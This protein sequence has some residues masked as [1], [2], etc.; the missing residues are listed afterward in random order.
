MISITKSRGAFVRQSFSDPN[1]PTKRLASLTGAIQR[2]VR[3]AR[4]AGE[5]RE[6][7]QRYRS[8]YVANTNQASDRDQ[9]RG[10]RQAAPFEKQHVSRRHA[11]P[12]RV[13]QR[14]DSRSDRERKSRYPEEGSSRSA[15][16]GPCRQHFSRTEGDRW[17]LPRRPPARDNSLQLEN[18]DQ[19]RSRYINNNRDDEVTDSRQSTESLPYREGTGRPS[20]QRSIAWQ[21]PPYNDERGV[22]EH[23]EHESMPLR[24][25]MTVPL[26][27]PRTSAASEFIYGTS[28]VF[29]ALQARARKLYTLYIYDGDSGAE[30]REG[31]K[32]IL[33]PAQEY[34][35]K[36]K[37]ISGDG[38][39]LLD[40]MAQGRPHNGYVLEASQL[41][42]TPAKA[43][44]SVMGRGVHFAFT[45]G[46][47][48]AEDISVNGT[49]RVIQC[50]SRRYPFV[51]MLDSI[52][53]PG[54]LGAVIRS[55][56]F[57]GVDAIALVDHGVA[58]I[59][60]VALKAS[61][62]AAEY[63]RYLSIKKDHDFVKTSQNNGW[64]FF[65]AVAP[66][67][68]SASR[69]GPPSVR[70][71][72]EEALMK[73]PCVLMLGGEGGGLKPR[74]QNEADGIV[75]I[76]GVDSPHSRVGLDSLNVSVA[77]ALLMQTFL[78][79]SNGDTRPKGAATGTGK[80]PE[81]KERLF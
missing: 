19:N 66:R 35:L 44:E 58:P 54:N 40:K 33:K 23:P 8:N 39:R 69:R 42:K 26:S 20:A 13:W 3:R 1:L 17:P 41:P 50:S 2:G 70:L 28:P 62:G 25:P 32:L 38:L 72:V 6:R 59:S 24:R 11:E 43:L 64:K 76:H 31:D 15:E 9:E 81:D 27:I 56:A 18:R 63:M 36:V 53:D 30:H 46:Y 71:E 55:A 75:S 51:L 73:G 57:F 52:L 79:R 49:S 4:E 47:Q 7:T 60:P 22:M 37:Q 48:S 65:A 61:A 78:R 29:A 77:A 74:L 68:K 21:P 45:T 5:A 10:L 14:R 67:S 80:P 12:E 16:D 34:G